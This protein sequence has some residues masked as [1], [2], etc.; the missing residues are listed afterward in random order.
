MVVKN[1]AWDHQKV[2]EA[3]ISA[4]DSLNLTQDEFCE[5]AGISVTTLRGI[6]QAIGRRTHQV[7]IGKIEQALGWETGT[8][9]KI[10]QGKPAP[11]GQQET[12]LNRL[13][14]LE[15]TVDYLQDQLRLV[16]REVARRGRTD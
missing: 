4:R 16:L 2:A 14:A 6:E 13:D 15:Q 3:I 7:N 1:A 5:R 10:A 12:I 11:I 9:A 8:I